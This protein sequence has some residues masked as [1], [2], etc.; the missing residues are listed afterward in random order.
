MHDQELQELGERYEAARLAYE[1]AQRDLHAKIRELRGEY[2][3]RRLADLSG[4]SFGRV[5]Q[6]TKD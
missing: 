3:L 4:L 2:T 1:A 5:H 6:L